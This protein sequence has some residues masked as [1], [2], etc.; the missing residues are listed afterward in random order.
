VSLRGFCDADQGATAIE[1][2]FIA[3]MLI[4]LIF[5]TIE[6]G[7]LGVMSTNLDSSLAATT[8]TIRVGDP[9]RPT[10]NSAFVDAVCANMIDSLNTC[11]SRLT[12]SVKTYASFAAASLDTSAPA[13][14]FNSGGAGD[15]VIVK[16]TYLWP[17]ILPLYAGNFQLAGPTQALLSS[18]A[19]FRNEPYE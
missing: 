1:F 4:A 7:A 8:R 3:P 2:A 19:T 16:A 6:I 12:T 14:Q 11:R 5:A 15:I 13:G 9:A 10:S 17:L 18:S